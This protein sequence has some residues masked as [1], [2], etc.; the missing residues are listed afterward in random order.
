VEK[1]TKMGNVMNEQ[2]SFAA[3]LGAVLGDAVDP[4]AAWD[5]VSKMNDASEMH[6]QR[7]LK[8]VGRR[9]K[10]TKDVAL[11]VGAVTPRGRALKK[12]TDQVV[13]KGG[14]ISTSG[15]PPNKKEV[16]VGQT[17][18]VV[19]TVGALNA[20]R[21]QAPASIKAMRG[22][23][24]GSYDKKLQT[25]HMPKSPPKPPSATKVKISNAART[26]KLAAKKV[27]GIK[28]IVNH[29][30]RSAA[31]VGGGF[32]ALHG[33]ELAGDAIAARAL[34]RQSKIAKRDAQEMLSPILAARKDGVITSSQAINMAEEIAKRFSATKGGPV[35][36]SY[37]AGRSIARKV[38]GKPFLGGPSESAYRSSMKNASRAGVRNL[39]ILGGAGALT[40]G[41]IA[42]SKPKQPVVKDYGPDM[43]WSAEISKVDEDKRQVFGWASLTSVD[44]QPVVDRQ[45]DYI[46]LDEIEKAAYHYVLSSRK[47]GDMHARDGEGPKH[48]ADL[49]ES[50]LVTP[51][52]L[53]HMGLAEDALPHGWW[54]GMK[55]QDDDQWEMVKKQERTGFSIHGKG[56]RIEKDL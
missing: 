21:H 39:A 25:G 9:A 40:A 24:K 38:T 18:N 12:L 43:E 48:T 2:E 30:G 35:A 23:S 26:T 36:G 13:V 17:L 27:P 45:G 32:L 7:N 19:A 54:I 22:W 53:K 6:V 20:I 37:R 15:K 42:L 47:G 46:P 10:K 5:V 56:S 41:A 29:P 51:E 8:V 50:F 31:V 3:V 14:S 34:H 55:V 44:G 28:S 11:T 16:R 52:K 1:S 49:I 4:Q 33:G